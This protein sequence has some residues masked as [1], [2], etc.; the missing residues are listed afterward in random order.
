MS[1]FYLC[2]G[3][4]SRILRYLSPDEIVRIL[5]DFRFV[6]LLL[7]DY[8]PRLLLEGLNLMLVLMMFYRIIIWRIDL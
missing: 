6:L 4:C 2:F 3:E 5:L 8:P 7:L 1:I